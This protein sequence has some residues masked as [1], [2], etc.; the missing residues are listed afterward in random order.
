MKEGDAP[1]PLIRLID[2]AAPGNKGAWFRLSPVNPFSRRTFCFAAWLH[3]APLNNRA[4][5]GAN[6]ATTM[7][8]VKGLCSRCQGDKGT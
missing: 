3:H 8:H 7:Q 5:K 1:L 2:L 4:S 6:M